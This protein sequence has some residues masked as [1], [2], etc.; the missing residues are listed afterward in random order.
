M[1]K[2]TPPPAN[3]WEGGFDR[4]LSAMAAGEAPSAQQ[5][6]SSDQASGEPPD[7]CSSDTQTPRDTSEDASR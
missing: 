7:P 4:L 5:K 1:T 2:I 3:E 6:R